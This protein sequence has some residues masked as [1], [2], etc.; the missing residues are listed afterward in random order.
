MAPFAGHYEP[1]RECGERVAKG[2]V[3]G[4]LHDFERIDLAPWPVCAGVDGVVI[5]QAWSAPVLQGQHI[6]CTGRLRAFQE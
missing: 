2:T 5:A 6:L 3:I 1:L 4:R